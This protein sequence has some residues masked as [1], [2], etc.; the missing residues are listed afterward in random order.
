MF[1]SSRV[2]HKHHY[3]SDEQSISPWYSYVVRYV[4]RFDFFHRKVGMLIIFWLCNSTLRDFCE[5]IIWDFISFNFSL[6]MEKT[7][8]LHFVNF[9]LY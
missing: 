3:K 2:S 7:T 8:S 1:N 6:L 4:I 9:P 5:E